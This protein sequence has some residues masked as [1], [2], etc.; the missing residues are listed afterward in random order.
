[1]RSARKDE[2]ACASNEF[3]AARHIWDQLDADGC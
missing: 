2:Y 3:N 1:M